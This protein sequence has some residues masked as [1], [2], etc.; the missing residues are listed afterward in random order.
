[1]CKP[2]ITHVLVDALSKL[3]NV[4]KLTSVPNQTTDASLFYKKPEWLNDV[5]DFLRIG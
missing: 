2:C 5:K 4:I 3:L 1:M